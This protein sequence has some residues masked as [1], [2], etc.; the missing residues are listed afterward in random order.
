MAPPILSLK[1]NVGIGFEG[2]N[3]YGQAVARTAFA[4]YLDAQ[5]TR[6]HGQETPATSRLAAREHVVLG[7]Y[8][9][10]FKVR[11]EFRPETIGAWL[12]AHGGAASVT[13]SQPDAGSNPTVYEHVINH[14]DTRQPITIEK[15]LGTLAKSEVLDG[16]VIEKLGIETAGP[17]SMFTAE[18]PGRKDDLSSSPTT[19]T[20]DSKAPLAKHQH[21]I[22]IAGATVGVKASRIMLGR[23]VEKGD[24][25]TGSRYRV[26]AEIGEVMATLQLDLLFRD[27]THL[28]RSLG[29]VSATAPQ[30]EPL[31][32]AMQALWTGPTIS[33]AFN[34]KLLIDFPRTFWEPIGLPTKGKDAIV[35]TIQAEVLYDESSAYAWRGTLTNTQTGL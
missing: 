19:P 32:T 12:K 23:H 20:F 13:T 21:T 1:G 8:D 5:I 28:Q 35:Q 16:G 31:Y 29:G 27:T 6:K 10:G 26:D 15:R 34:Q 3:A 24:F 4:R 14:M 17:L 7:D 25:E 2:V 11:A 33:G 30:D 18:G 9:P 22:K